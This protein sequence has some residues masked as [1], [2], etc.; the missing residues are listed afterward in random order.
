MGIFSFYEKDVIKFPS[1]MY[2]PQAGAAVLISDSQ[3]SREANVLAQFTIIYFSF[4][5]FLVTPM[6]FSNL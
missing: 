3:Y 2:F 4:C 6:Y 5:L 1:V